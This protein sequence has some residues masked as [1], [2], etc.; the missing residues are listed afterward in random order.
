MTVPTPASVEKPRE[1]QIAIVPL[2]TIDAKDVGRGAAQFDAWLQS[3]SGGVVTLERI[4]GVAGALPVVGNIMALVDALGDIVTLARSKQRELLDWVSLGINLIGVLPA[5]PTMAAARMSLRPTLFLVRQELR[6]SAKALLGDSLIQVLVGHLNATIVGTIDDFVK[7]AQPKVAGILDDAG[8]LGQNAVN[9]IA[10]G[11][12]AVVNGKLDAKGDLN[13]ASSKLSAAG[14]Q[15]LHDPK[16]AI[17][18]MFGAAFSA[19]KAVGKGVANSAANNLLPDKA[20]ALV[21]GNTKILREMGAELPRQ[22]GRLADPATQHSIGWLLQMLSGAVAGFRKRKAHGQ[23]AGVKPNA[24]SQARHQAGDGRLEATGQ[25]APA[26]A[27]PNPEKNV[28]C[29][30]TG[31]SISFALGSESVTHNDFSLA[32]PFSVTWGRT[33]CSRLDAYDTGS[34]GARWITEFTTRIDVTEDGVLFHAA[35]GRSH[36]YPLP[37]IGEAHFDPIE[38]LTLLHA[39]EGKLILCRGFE[40][41]EVYI[42]RGMRY[43]LSGIE[44]RSGA[45]MMLHYE[46]RHG[47]EHVL[48]DLI[49]YQGDVT[50]VHLQLAT[51]VDDRGRVTGFWEVRDGVPLRQLCAYQYDDA[52]D[53]VQAQDENGAAWS[54]QYQHHLI[55][56]YTDRTGRGM[57][58]QWQGHDAKAKAVHEWAD[59]GSYDTRLEWDENIRL[60]YVTDAHGNETWHYYDILGYTY[61]IRHPDERS[62]WLFRDEA[63]NVIRHVHTDGTTDR[64][65][66]DERGNVLEHIRADDSVVHYAYDDKNQLVK[67]SDAEGGQWQRSYDDQGNLVESVDPLGNKTEYAYTAAGLPK[68]VKDANG[69]ERKLEYNEAGQLIEYVDCSGKKSAWA[70]DERGQLIGFTNP[71]GETTEYEYAA[72]QLVLIRYPDN[73]EDRFERDAEGRVLLHIDA[74]GQCTTWHYNAVGLIDERTDAADQTVR[75]RWDRLGRLSALE[76]ENDRRAQ[77]HYDSMGRVLEE[78]GFDGR[79][80]RYQ[81]APETGRLTSILNGERKIA[82]TFDAMGRLTERRA[83]LAEQSQSE[84]FDYDANG[85]LIMACNAD[86]RLQWFHDPAGNLLRE[87]QH[88]LGLKQ[89]AV[90]V[91]LHEYDAL[92]QRVATVRPDG[93]RISW[94]TYGSGHLLGVR[95]DDHELVSYERDDMHR[96][97]ARHQGNLLW[98]KQTW[99]PIGRLQEQAFGRSDDKAILLKREYTYDAVGQLIDIA[100]TRRGHLSY[101]YDPVGRLIKATSRLGVETFAFDPASNLLDEHTQKPLRPLDQDQTRSRLLDNLLR[102]YSGKH[103]DYDD[104]GNLILRWQNGHY[105]RLQWDLFDRL[106]H[107]DDARLAV[108][109]AY[110]ALGRRLYK[111]SRVHYKQRPEAGSQWNRNEL[112]RK[113]SEM[114]CGFTLYG[115]D[116]DHLA[117]ESSPAQLDGTVGHT[118]HYVYEPGTFIPLVQAVR[119]Q[120]ISLLDLPEYSGDYSLEEDPVWTHKQLAQPFDA[121][122]WYQC[123]HLGTPQELTDQHANIVWSAQYKAWGEVR[124]HLGPSAIQHQTTNPIRFQG[125]YH[126]HETGLHYSRYRYYDPAI[127]RFIS[128]DPV[129]YAGGLNLYAYAVNPIGWIDPL[130]LTSKELAAAMNADGIPT[131]ANSA[132]HHIVGENSARAKPA[133]DILDKHDI[134]VDSGVNGVF[135]PN[136][137][138]VDNMPGIRHCGRHPNAYIDTVNTR[139]I[140]ADTLGG[141]QAVLTELGT[142]RGTLQSAQR[143]AEWA[144]VLGN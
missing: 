100:D 21:L 69:A 2:N 87:H 38:N 84:S 107:F 53:L 91:W 49:T 88:Y 123:D 117:W 15:L 42:R 45:G 51:L 60:T 70:Y 10:K 141:K 93:H 40:R 95:L 44:L 4:K 138:N 131:P 102:E 6:N 63:K 106:V 143:N 47:D 50:K 142:L 105:S 82:L 39:Q 72:G 41:K 75:Y 12:D 16:A 73:T 83:E 114:N 59:D 5:P 37:K 19:Y 54:Y 3:I 55:T 115:W 120:P 74:L 66:Y 52:G 96:E 81:Y 61:R 108:D 116:G 58:L 20:K 9:E 101:Q 85:K 68:A 99:D 11:L 112:A 26:S 30:I 129:S 111:D 36:H 121:L 14:G 78:S 110:D 48:S 67:I 132:A 64:Y 24:T 97:V 22:L 89:P 56:R 92:N 133:R 27:H 8:K 77:F 79:V 29:P 86:S 33:Y 46:H 25:Q 113:Q 32:G 65:R 118:V 80:T 57:N 23:S 43:V 136:K 34:L 144:N 130:G 31:R 135:L 17:S 139:I 124:E 35:D 1:P 125:Q 62:E 127:G 13:V 104:R 18:N 76:N 126:D 122:A 28:V 109:Y 98:Q 137:D 134:P 94:L 103:Y 90:A 7:Q 119:H 71:A 128:K 140:A